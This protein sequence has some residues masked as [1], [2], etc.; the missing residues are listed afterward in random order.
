MIQLLIL[1]VNGITKYRIYRRGCESWCARAWCIHRTHNK[2][3]C[4]TYFSN[5]SF[6][7]LLTPCRHLDDK[8][9]TVAERNFYRGDIFFLFFSF[10]QFKSRCS[11]SVSTRLFSS[12]SQRPFFLMSSPMQFLH[13]L[14]HL[15]I[16]RTPRTLDVTLFSPHHMCLP[17]YTTSF[18]TSSKPPLHRP[19]PGSSHYEFCPSLFFHRPHQ[20]PQLCHI[21]FLF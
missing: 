14:F 20:H 2:T 17:M 6:V 19:S 9:R 4:R 10:P 16:Q 18:E 13:C 15:H 12:L 1:L 3:V 21:Q 11:W 5:D 8:Q 7:S